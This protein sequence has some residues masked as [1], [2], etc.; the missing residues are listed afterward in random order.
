MWFYCRNFTSLID[1]VLQI[2]ISEPEKLPEKPEEKDVAFDQDFTLTCKD[3]KHCD[4]DVSYD[5]RMLQ[6]YI[7]SQFFF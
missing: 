5:F 7:N 4:D 3:C 2:F 6:N 1:G